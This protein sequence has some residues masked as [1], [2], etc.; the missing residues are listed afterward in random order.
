MTKPGYQKLTAG[1]IGVW[2]IFSLTISGLHV[3]EGDPG[4]PPLALGLSVVLPILLF[5]V[6]YATSR[7]FRQFLLDLN[8][9]AL[10]LVHSWR[11]VGF[12]FLVLAS[13]GILP[14][15]FALPAGWGD[16]AIGATAPL[17][18]ATLINPRRRNGFLLWQALGILDLVT[19]IGLGTTARLIEPA[20]V[21]TNAMVVL[22]LSLIPT[23]VVPLL[24]I[25]HMISIAQ[26]R[27][28]SKSKQP[29][30]RNAIPSSAV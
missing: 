29:D 25:L 11:L 2:F 15:L 4:R 13:Y 6:W 10:T 22:P 23:F 16:I 1:L 5:L 21:A 7:D 28:W 12:A 14:R 17:V 18:A 27:Q 20:A 30:L 8:P 26:A 9:R 19:A 24:L 3:L